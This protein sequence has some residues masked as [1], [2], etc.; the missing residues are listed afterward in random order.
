MKLKYILLGL[1]LPGF[2]QEMVASGDTPDLP[3]IVNGV[4]WYD[5]RDSIVSAHGANILRDN[6][7][8]WMFGE[9]KTDSTNNFTGF[10]C[11]SSSDLVNWKFE[12]IALRRQ[13]DGI[14]GQGRV[15]ERPKV[16]K[17]PATGKYV[18][19]MHSD[20]SRYKD[21]CV[22]YATSSAVDGEYEFQGSLLY[23]GQPIRKW[24][25]G[26]FVDHDGK[27][28]LLV[29]HG[30]IYRFADDLQSLDSCMCKGVKGV[31]ES[32]AMVHK[33]GKYYW[34]SSHTTSWERNDN[35]Y[36]S[37][38]SLS[39]PWEQHELFAPKGSN[40]W[41]SQTTFVLPIENV[42]DTTYMYMGDRWSFPKQ[43][44]AAT[45]V[46]QPLQWI[47]GEPAL[48]DYWETW[49]PQTMREATPALTPADNFRWKGV[50]PGEAYTCRVRMG[51]EGR[52]YIKGN[53]SDHSAYAMIRIEDKNGKVIADT[54]VDF[55]SLAP[56]EGLRYISPEL[57]SGEYLVRIEV[58][59][60]KSNWSDKK[61]NNYG[62][63]GYDVEVTEVGFIR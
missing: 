33:D 59:D 58:A 18:M 32:P 4:P 45:Y 20:N 52:I 17:S 37:S 26:S 9:F 51:K 54:P 55:Y 27:A 48:P 12:R 29:H 63:K 62:S 50:R 15:G 28:Y 41:N 35:M 44:S 13:A 42:N 14:M 6:G 5:Q 16:L 7:K 2:C 25:I 43:R 53:T 8:Y 22:A 1:A 11:Y 23:K 46:W 38:A 57:G 39:G 61:R 30:E 40:T 60:M 34:F 10:S 47:D 49:S 19:I 3:V 56:A 36:A 24:D 31:G 21:P